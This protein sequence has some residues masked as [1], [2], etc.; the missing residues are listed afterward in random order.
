VDGVGRGIFDEEGQ[1]GRDGVQEEG[2][3]EDVDEE[4]DE[5]ASTH[6]CGDLPPS[7]EREGVRV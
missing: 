6:D 3:Q 5:E 1:E 4:E 7:P 2:E